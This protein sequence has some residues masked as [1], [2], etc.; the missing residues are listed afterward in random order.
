M[1]DMHKRVLFLG[2]VTVVALS[3]GA[4]REEEQG[5]LLS[6]QAGKYLGSN[7]DKTFSKDI[8]ASLRNRTVHQSGVSKPIGGAKIS[9]SASIDGAKLQSM[10]IRAWSQSGRQ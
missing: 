8:T 3:L 10:R 5:R 2:M 6:F 9:G 4:C 7:P 1:A